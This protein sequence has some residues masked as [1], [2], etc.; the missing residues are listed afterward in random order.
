MSSSRGVSQV[1]PQLH[2]LMRLGLEGILFLSLQVMEG[3][4]AQLH[5]SSKF[6]RFMCPFKVDKLNGF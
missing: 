1:G 5:V 2:S 4:C 3:H 6:N